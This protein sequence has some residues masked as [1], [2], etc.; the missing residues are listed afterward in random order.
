MV[1]TEFAGDP[2]SFLGSAS[3][4]PHTNGGLAHLVAVRPEQL[5]LVPEGLP[6]ARAVLAEPLAV[7]L[8]ALGRLPVP[9]AG[10]RVLVCGAG[11]IGLLTALCLKSRGATE[12]TL[13]DLHRRP[14]DLALEL[15]ADHAVQVPGETPTADEYDIVIEATGRRPPSTPRCTPQPWAGTSCSSACSPASR[16]R[17]S[18]PRW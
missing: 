5:R 16:S 12:V 17:L 7:V 2:M 9:V 8:H 6:P 4:L 10:R 11:P 14:L 15:G 13:T 18:S 3:T 1:R